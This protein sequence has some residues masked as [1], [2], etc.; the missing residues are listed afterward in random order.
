MI[1]LLAILNIST[2]IL[3]WLGWPSGMAGHEI[4]TMGKN[5]RVQ[6]LLEDELGFDKAQTEKFL[7]LRRLHTESVRPLQGEIRLLK[8][9]MFDGVLSDNPQPTLSDSLLELTLEKQ[10]ELER[11]TFQYFLDL[12]KMCTPDQQKKL[13]LLMH[14]VMHPPNARPGDGRPVP[15][16]NGQPPPP[17]QPQ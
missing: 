16:R 2:L 14:D 8:K 5:R 17:R 13:R 10:V 15:L 1:V 6:R 9:Q 4:Q 7:Q 12:K 11:L 3:L